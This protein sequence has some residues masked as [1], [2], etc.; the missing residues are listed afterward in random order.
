MYDFRRNKKLCNFL[1]NTMLIITLA[2]MFI[3]PFFGEW[4]KA[5]YNIYQTISAVLIIATIC[6]TFF[7]SR[8]KKASKFVDKIFTEIDDCGY[9]LLANKQK[10]LN[11]FSLSC[12]NSLGTDFFEVNSN[13]MISGRFFDFV[14]QKKKET[15]YFAKQKKLTKED[16]FE[17]SDIVNS[18]AASANVRQKQTIVLAIA[19]EKLD[20]DV[21]AYTKMTTELGKVVVYPLIVSIS[22]GKTYFLNDGK[23]EINFALKNILCYSN[24]IISEQYRVNEKL[25][26]QKDLEK[27]MDGFEMKLFREGKFN[28]RS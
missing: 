22:D 1:F 21:I 3:A 6:S 27:R 16:F 8:Y 7:F 14:A 4:F 18:A 13:V 17:F 25:E 19:C 15:V 9:Y 20:E 2:F 10:D 26:F 5:N 24:G 28:P 12:Y 11:E 23:G